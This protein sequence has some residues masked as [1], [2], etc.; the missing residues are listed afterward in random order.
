MSYS[1][2]WS[3]QTSPVKIR[4]IV[5]GAATSSVADATVK[6]KL[7]GTTNSHVAFVF[8][9]SGIYWRAATGPDCGKAD[10]YLDGVKVQILHNT[11]EVWGPSLVTQGKP[12]SHDF[13]LDVAAGDA[14]IFCVNKNGT[15]IHDSATWDPV[16]TFVRK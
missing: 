14:V 11:A 3:S 4:T 15:S 5:T 1:D 16:V 9:G 10:V 6:A 7:S 2:G 12:A 13:T 8:T